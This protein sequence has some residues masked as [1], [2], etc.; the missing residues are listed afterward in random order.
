MGVPRYRFR[1]GV[2][3]LAAE[4]DVEKGHIEV[5]GSCYLQSVVEFISVL[6]T[7]QPRSRSI[8]SKLSDNIAS[9][10]TTNTCAPRS[11]DMLRLRVCLFTNSEVLPQTDETCCRES[12]SRYLGSFSTARAPPAGHF[13]VEGVSLCCGSDKIFAKA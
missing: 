7:T 3:A 10:S 13:T 6:A 5:R 8:A 12:L 1:H 9:S 2:H 11:D 4:V